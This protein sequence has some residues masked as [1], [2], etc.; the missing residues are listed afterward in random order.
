MSYMRYDIK[1]YMDKWY[2]VELAKKAY[3]KGVPPLPGREDWVDVEGLLILP[4]PHKVM[5]GRPKKNRRKEPREV[6][7]RP[8]HTGVG[9]M[10][11]KMGG[12]DALQPLWTISPQCEGLQDD[13]RGGCCFTTTTTKTSRSTTS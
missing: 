12:T 5:P 2:S 7:T 3:T 11:R 1:G 13:S 6:S 8:S 4:P 10:M 9:T